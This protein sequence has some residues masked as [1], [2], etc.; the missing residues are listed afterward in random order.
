MGCSKN[1]ET[2]GELTVRGTGH[3]SVSLIGWQFSGARTGWAHKGSAHLD[4]KLWVKYLV[5][6]HAWVVEAPQ[7]QKS[8]GAEC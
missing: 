5:Y 3:R 8:L 2:C 7:G 1:N 4:C 6:V